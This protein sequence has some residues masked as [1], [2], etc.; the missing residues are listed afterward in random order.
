MPLCIITMRNENQQKFYN[1][2]LIL[3][4]YTYIWQEDR[5]ISSHAQ[6]NYTIITK[7]AS[8]DSNV[9]IYTSKP[10]YIKMLITC[11]YYGG[12]K[13]ENNKSIIYY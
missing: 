9:C 12:H 3:N 11:D 13:S 4:T 8:L 5:I 1:Y 7:M 2:I 10:H 6:N